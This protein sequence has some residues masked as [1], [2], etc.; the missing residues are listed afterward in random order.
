MPEEIKRL[1][2]YDQQF[3]REP[4]F[5]DEQKYHNNMRRRLNRS[6]HTTGVVEGLVVT[7]KNDQEITV[8]TGMALD[9]AGREIVLA[10]PRDVLVDVSVA[11]NKFVIIKYTEEQTDPPPPEYMISEADRTRWTESSM[12][13]VLDAAPADP[14]EQIILAELTI[15]NNMIE[16]ISTGTPP[17]HRRVTGERSVL[18]YV[19]RA[20]AKVNERIYQDRRQFVPLL[21][22]SL[23]GVKYRNGRNATVNVG[24]VP[25]E[26]TFDGSHVWVA[27][28][29]SNTISKIDIMTNSEVVTVHVN[30]DPRGIAFDGLH[31]W[32]ANSGS[33]EV[34]KINITTN[35]VVATVPVNVDPRGIA[36]DGSHI[37]VANRGSN[38]VSKIDVMTNDVVAT[39]SL[40][41]FPSIPPDP[42]GLVTAEPAGVAFDGSH[43]WVTN[44]NADTVSKIDIITN[45][46]VDTVFVRGLDRRWPERVAFDGSHIWVVNSGHTTISKIDIMTNTVE[47][48]FGVGASPQ[49]IAFDGSHIWI[50]NSNID[51]VSKIDI[52]T[53]SVVANVDVSDHPIGIV[54]DGSH[55]WVANS[56]SN[57][58]NKIL[59]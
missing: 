33:N 48:T 32:V 45:T 1:N 7:K 28:S 4:D 35:T 18:E 2:Y 20:T 29:G 6:L 8:S 40:G 31:I 43:I 52:V 27:N 9:G 44:S 23:K 37:W 42:P 54:F 5:T 22:F 21:A 38:T 16:E 30:N 36:F 39:V 34:S 58:L 47:G 51:K 13:E 12:I 10:D 11:G 59:I 24:D 55:I 49:G 50:S 25:M 57:N 15:D 3:L 56:D 17:N 41:P 53:N 26:I 19:D 14:G 46:E